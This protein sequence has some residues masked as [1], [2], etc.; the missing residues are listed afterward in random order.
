MDAVDT[1]PMDIMGLDFASPE[2][3]VHET[4]GSDEALP[5]S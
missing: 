4:K 1:C 2:P 5:E 3:L